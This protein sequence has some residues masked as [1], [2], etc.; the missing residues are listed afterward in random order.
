MTGN[1]FLPD[2]KNDGLR[3]LPC[4]AADLDKILQASLEILDEVQVEQALDLSLVRQLIIARAREEIADYT[5]LI[6][7]DELIGW[8]HII[9]TPETIELDD[10]NIVEAFRSMG[11]GSRLLDRVLE[12]G[13]VKK[14]PVKV[15]VAGDNT[16]AVRFY[17]RHG[18][19][20]VHKSEQ[21][22][23]CFIHDSHLER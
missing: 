6:K 4:T 2:D 21:H 9:E 18:F 15:T 5:K 14:K 12:E 10:V 19:R 3:F 17:E 11:Y 23:L 22:H 16:G 1:M 20:F 7:G 8:Y 13:R